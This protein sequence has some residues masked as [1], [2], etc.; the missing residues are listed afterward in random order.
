MLRCINLLF[1]ITKIQKLVNKNVVIN[2]KLLFKRINLNS[3]K[4]II[5]FYAVQQFSSILREFYP[6]FLQS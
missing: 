3:E 5:N 1:H 2:V 6:V 4:D